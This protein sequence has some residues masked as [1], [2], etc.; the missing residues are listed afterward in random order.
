MIYAE[1][2]VAFILFA[3]LVYMAWDELAYRWHARQRRLQ[4]EAAIA[5]MMRY[6]GDDEFSRKMRKVRGEIE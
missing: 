1:Y 5:E 6:W 2:T 3:T 4:R